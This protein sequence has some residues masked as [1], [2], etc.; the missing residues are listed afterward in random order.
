MSKNQI[1]QDNLLVWIFSNEKVASECIAVTEERFGKEPTSEQFCQVAT[2]I[3]ARLRD[4]EL[5]KIL[6]P[7]NRK[8]A[9]LEIRLMKA[10]HKKQEKEILLEYR[11]KERRA[12]DSENFWRTLSGRRIGNIQQSQ[13]MR[14]RYVV[15]AE[16]AIKQADIDL[17]GLEKLYK[18]TSKYISKKTA[19]TNR[20][21]EL[22]ILEED[23]DKETV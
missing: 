22:Y 21:W 17:E 3:A 12:N 16:E 6:E 5:G 20:K 4:Q 14:K 11:K 1:V 13:L 15:Q 10:R 18:D 9:V 8:L 19:E 7:Y 2:G 23:Y